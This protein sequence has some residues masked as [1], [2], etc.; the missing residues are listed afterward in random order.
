MTTAFGALRRFVPGALRRIVLDALRWLV[1]GRLAFA[2]LLLCLAPH[3]A[4]E[5]LRMQFKAWS[6]TCAGERYCSASTRLRSDDPQLRYAYLLRVSRYESGER[7]IAFLPAQERPAADAEITVRVDGNAAA[8]LAPESGWRAVGGG[9]TVLV[10]GADQVASLLDAMRTG[11]RVELRYRS[12]RD[13]PVE[14]SF[15]LAGF[16]P[17]LAVVDPRPAKRVHPKPDTQSAAAPG[18]LSAAMS[19]SVAAASDTLTAASDPAAAVVAARAEPEPSVE[20]MPEVAPVR[21]DPPANPALA[22]AKP[23]PASKPASAAGPPPPG[24]RR[25]KAVR[26]FTCRGDEPAWNLTIDNNR[27]RLELL[28]DADP[29]SIALTGRLGVTGEGRTPDVDWRGKSADG[30][31][32]RALIQ[33]QSCTDSMSEAQGEAAF[34][35]RVQLTVPRGGKLAGCCDAGLEPRVAARTQPEPAQV[36]VAALGAKSPVDWSRMLMELLPAIDACLAKTPGTSP[37]VTKAW[38]MNHGMVGVR[39]RNATVG[40]FEC[41]AQTDGKAVDRFGPVESNAPAVPGEE[42]V[43]Y[44]AIA[45]APPSGNCFT[46]ERVMD[47]GGNQI[48]WLST[49]TCAAQPGQAEERRE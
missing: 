27:A 8:R 18:D 4:A 38:P 29:A 14:V 46:H 35:Y 36:P 3:A 43:L 48:G 9:N 37:Y 15:P 7:E 1:P 11:K 39:T 42:T 40:W 16:A 21:A 20:V 23:K 34:D 17:A 5:E 13:K 33:Q 24:R 49:N 19:D 25:V 44:T 45:H 30:R 32:Y 26:Q 6:V 41:V 2:S 31:A 22:Q 12:T 28:L 10:A 47:A